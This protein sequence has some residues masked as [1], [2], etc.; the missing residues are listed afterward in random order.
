MEN[1]MRL[2]L[3]ALLAA[4]ALAQ[5]WTPQAGNTTASLRGVS[6]V[7]QKV[8]YASG[9]GGAWLV[10]KDAGATWR[11]AQVP[12]A[13]QLDFRAV[14]A[15]DEQTV[16]LLSIGNGD[17][18]RIY[19]TADGGGHWDL[20]MTNPDAKGFLDEL[21]FWDSLHGIVL[22]D[23]VDGQF[24]IFTTADGGKTWIRRHAPAAV[25]GEGAFAASNTSLAVMGTAEAWFGTGGPG[26]ARV[27]HSVDGG[28]TWTV[29]STPIRNDAAAA[30][31]FSLAFS[32]SR[33]GIAVGG[34]YSKAAEDLNN[35]AV[36]SDGGIS[37][38]EPAN[39]PHGFR[40]AVAWLEGRKAW[41]VTG[42]SGSDISTDGGNTWKNFDSGNYNA[43][44]VAA[45]NAAW[46]VG[47]RGRIAALIP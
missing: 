1:A 13:E 16:C 32:D 37:W 28:K 20:L 8:V 34:D 10:T 12:G 29:A 40:S 9:S 44:G 17:K 33:H 35:V 36:T 45:G 5:N 4:T 41:L 22:G 38:S 3:A 19:K 47:P 11:A 39:R 23:P 26:G 21:A 30:G 25:P 2:L 15:V 46:A 31:I 7:N 14:H 18:S 6:A 24:A 42:T 27:F 43:L